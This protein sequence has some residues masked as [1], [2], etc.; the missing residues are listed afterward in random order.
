M[1]LML[2][3]AQQRGRRLIRRERI[4]RD[5]TN[6]LDAYDDDEIRKKYRL[7][8]QM[9]LALHDEISVDIEP[10][11]QRN[12]AVPAILQ[13]FCALRYYASGSFQEVLGDAHGLHKSTI[14]RI[15]HRVS[16]ALCRR[17]HQY[18][19][20]PRQQAQQQDIME[21]FHD[22]AG[23]PRILGAVDGVLIIITAPFE[24]E[25][26]YVGRKGDHCL[27]ILAI[28]DAKLKFTYAVVRF[29]GSTHDSFI[30]RTSN[31]CAEFENGNFDGWLLGD[32]G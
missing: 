28:C 31:L 3:I 6:P 18:I 2:I 7:T 25:P 24:D 4:F 21:D 1:A 22:I 20:F 23:F 17:R 26:L 8:R 16:T 19:Q 9:I 15:I 14:S 30:W 5:R 27:N 10:Q 11:T 32:S 13:L 29:P 12:H